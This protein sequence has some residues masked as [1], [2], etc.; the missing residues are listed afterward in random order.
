MGKG[1][2]F[3]PESLE[4]PWEGP[5]RVHGTSGTPEESIP[6]K[7]KPDDNIVRDDWVYHMEC[8]ECS[9]LWDEDCVLF[10]RDCKPE[11]Q[12]A[13]NGEDRYKKMWEKLKFGFETDWN[14]TYAKEWILKRLSELES[15]QGGL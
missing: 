6:A 7:W 11:V 15:S 8:P 5:K 9:Y 4:Q 12:R 1:T 14:D 13:L 3:E 10:V 2:H